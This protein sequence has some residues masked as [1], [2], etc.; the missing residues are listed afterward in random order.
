MCVNY[1]DLNKHCKKDP[2]GLPRIDQVV[3]STTSYT[4]LY[5]LDCYSGY[6]QISLKE[7]DQIKTSFIMPYGAFCYKTMS[8]R[9]KNTGATYQ[10]AIQ[11]CLASQLHHN[12]EAYVDDV[13]VKTKNP[14]DLIADLTETFDNLRKFRWKLNPTKCVFGV[15]SG[16]L[17]GF[18]VSERGIE[19]NPEKIS[20]IMNM[21]PP[22]MARDVQKLTGCMAALNRFISKLGERGMEFFK[23]LKKQDN[24]V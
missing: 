7:E 5:F 15:P 20:T 2:F 24:F 10:R 3:D 18:I 12:V 9:L 14:D 19:A 17:L 1:T 13:V 16:K 4:L 21:P 8:F 11:M 23:L 22:K 6:H